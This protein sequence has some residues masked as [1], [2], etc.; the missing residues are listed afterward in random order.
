[1]LRKPICPD[2][3]KTLY[4]SGETLKQIADRFDC[5]DKTVS[6]RARELGLQHPKAPERKHEDT[7]ASLVR[8]N[9]LE[10]YQ[11]EETLRE[12]AKAAGTS[13]EGVR[14]YLIRNGVKIRTRAE[15]IAATMQKYGT[16]FHKTE[17]RLYVC[18]RDT[19]GLVTEVKMYRNK[20][21]SP[22]VIWGKWGVVC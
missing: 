19:Y 10:R 13:V 3:L 6:R 2:R 17:S 20:S 7:E 1:M 18:K 15:G 4:A 11:N 5:T 16:R 12:I 22:V 8:V 21:R 14:I 9:A